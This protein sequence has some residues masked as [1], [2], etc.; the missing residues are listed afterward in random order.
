MAFVGLI[1]T[2]GEKPS[3]G[4]ILIPILKSI[5]SHFYTGYK[6]KIDE[7]RTLKVRGLITSILCDMAERSSLVNQVPVGSFSACHI[8][9]SIGIGLAVGVR[10]VDINAQRRTPREFEKQGREAL[11]LN[12]TNPGKVTNYRGILGPTSLSILPYALLPRLVSIDTMHTI[13]LGVLK[14][15]WTMWLSKKNQHEEFYLSENLLN[16]IN[17]RLNGITIP[18]SES[19]RLPRKLNEKILSKFKAD[20]FKHLSQTWGPLILKGWV[21]FLS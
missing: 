2:N 20:E 18:N 7:K 15:M 8:C 3:Y 17:K 10:Y 5:R 12:I 14:A 4:S 11:R 21:L 16:I 9:H 19:A 6:L 13:S 1:K